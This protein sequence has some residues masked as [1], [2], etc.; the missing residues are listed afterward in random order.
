M[1]KLEVLEGM[2]DDRLRERYDV[3]A[4][5]RQPGPETYLQIMAWRKQDRQTTRITFMTLVM[6]VATIINVLIALLHCH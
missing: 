1:E 3:E 6:T 5:F 2:S 4:P